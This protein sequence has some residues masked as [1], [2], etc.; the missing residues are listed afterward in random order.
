MKDGYYEIVYEGSSAFLIKH[1]SSVYNKEGLD[2]Y[3]YSTEKYVMYNGRYL[4]FNSNSSFLKVFG[5]RSKDIGDYMKKSRINV[6]KASRNE[7]SKILEY[8]DAAEKQ[9][10]RK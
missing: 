5:E 4:K 2:K 7:V 9:G 3:A 6:R 1:K 10:S 8:A